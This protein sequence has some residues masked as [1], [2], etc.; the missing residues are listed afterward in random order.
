MKSVAQHISGNLN[1]L[2]HQV[3]QPGSPSDFRAIKQSFWSDRDP[4]IS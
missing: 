4:K 1:Q 3:Y 2:R